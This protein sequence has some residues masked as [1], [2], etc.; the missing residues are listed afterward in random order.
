MCACVHCSRMAVLRGG[1]RDAVD[2]DV[3]AGQLLAERLGQRDDAGLRRAVGGGVRV[4]F[5]AGDGRDRDDAAVVLLDHRRHDRPAAVEDA[6]QVDLDHLLPLVDRILPERRRCGRRCRRWRP[7]CRCRPA[8]RWSPRRRLRRRRR[9]RDRPPRCGRDRSASARER[10][11][12]GACASRSHSETRAPEASRRSATAR[13]MP[14]APPVTTARRPPRSIWFM[15]RMVSGRRPRAV[16][17][18]ARTVW[19][20]SPSPATPSVIRLPGRR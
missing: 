3:V 9:R 20:C 6:V 7:G 15:A 17:A 5:L 19:C 4:A 18:S 2:R 1:G 14:C 10:C 8:P 13:P 16:Y 11:R 12:P